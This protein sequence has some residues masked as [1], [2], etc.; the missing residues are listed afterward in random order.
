M[1]STLSCSAVCAASKEAEQISDKTQKPLLSTPGDTGTIQLCQLRRAT[2]TTSGNKLCTPHV[3]CSAA[4]WWC[5][6]GFHEKLWF[7]YE[8]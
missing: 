5:R 2:L 8:E 3:G 1:T 7:F 4:V 6:K